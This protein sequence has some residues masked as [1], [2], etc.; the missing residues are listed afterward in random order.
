MSRLVLDVVQRPRSGQWLHTRLNWS[1][2]R[3]REV[4]WRM[5]AGRGAEP[6]RYPRP[7]PGTTDR[8]AAA[9]PAGPVTAADFLAARS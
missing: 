8:A 3:L 5:R 6:A 1:A 2:R 7:V 4:R 9:R